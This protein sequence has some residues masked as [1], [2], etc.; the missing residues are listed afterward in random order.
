[1][2]YTVKQD[3]LIRAKERAAG[4]G[5]ESDIFL[6][7]FLDFSAGV[8]TNGIVHYRPFLAAAV[9]LEQSPQ[10]KQLKKA[11]N[12]EFT[13]MVEAIASL[14][15]L[16]LAYDLAFRLSLPDGMAAAEPNTKLKSFIF[17]TSGLARR[18]TP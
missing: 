15:K 10:F 1:M 13:G 2:Q 18:N 3:A 11:D 7:E 9:W 5:S 14:R 8:D 4:A 17:G 16:Q 12:V 6:G